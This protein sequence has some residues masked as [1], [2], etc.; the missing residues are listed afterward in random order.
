MEQRYQIEALLQASFCKSKITIHLGLYCSII[1]KE[2]KRYIR[3]SN[4][5]FGEYCA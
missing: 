1:C 2:V 3:K 5:G 4:T